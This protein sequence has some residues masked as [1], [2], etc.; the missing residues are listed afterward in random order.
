MQYVITQ[1]V[2]HAKGPKQTTNYY[3]SSG[4]F[5][6]SWS[7]SKVKAKR[8]PTYVHARIQASK[9]LKHAK[10]IRVEPLQEIA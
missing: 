5:F 6:T 10:G 7:T 3:V 4:P 1:V 8:F 2:R 9:L